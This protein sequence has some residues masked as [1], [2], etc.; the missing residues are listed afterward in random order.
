MSLDISREVLIGEIGECI[1]ATRLGADVSSNQ[2]DRLKDMIFKDGKTVEVKTQVRYRLRSE[3]TVRPD[4]LNKCLNVDRLIFV[5]YDDTNDVKIY[6]CV[7]RNDYLRYN[8]NDGRQMIGWKINEMEL[9]HTVH[10]QPLSTLLRHPEALPGVIN[11]SMSNR[12]TRMRIMAGL[13]A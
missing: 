7:N 11:K 2:F 8:T 13:F 12:N 6:E 3:F 4:Q 9:L 5:E 10:S 1:V